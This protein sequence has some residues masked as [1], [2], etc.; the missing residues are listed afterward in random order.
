ML[1]AYLKH[2][3]FAYFVDVVTEEWHIHGPLFGLLLILSAPL[4]IYLQDLS[5]HNFLFRSESPSVSQ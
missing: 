4:Q 2:K 5:Q 1:L 3:E